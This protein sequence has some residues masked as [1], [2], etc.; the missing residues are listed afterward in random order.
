MHLF[1]KRAPARPAAGVIG[2][3][4]DCGSIQAMETVKLLLDIGTPLK[5]RLLHISG[6]DMRCHCMDLSPNPDCPA[7]G[8][9]LVT[10]HS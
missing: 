1:R 2:A 9:A 7:C 5:N 3:A 8:R 6:L 10:D 4:R